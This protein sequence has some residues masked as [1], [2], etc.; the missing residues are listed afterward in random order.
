VL[1]DGE[2]VKVSERLFPLTPCA[3][4][5]D[6]EHS[7]QV[8]YAVIADYAFATADNKI[9]VI[10]IFDNI[11]A[12]DFPFS[13]PPF[14]LVIGIHGEPSEAG[15]QFQ[16]EILLWDEDG[17]QLFANEAPFVFAASDFPGQRSTF[18]AMMGFV[19]I[20]LKKAGTYSFIVKV[21]GEERTRVPLVV[22]HSKG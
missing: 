3:A 20:P 14:F 9:G 11:F 7:M 22:T 17:A 10:G 21:N 4:G 6:N 2:A 5:T 16:M 13:S 8:R 1:A 18:N 19:G 12:K 15:K